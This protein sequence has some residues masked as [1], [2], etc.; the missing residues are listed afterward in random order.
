MMEW[1][2]VEKS[3]PRKPEVMIMADLLK[4]TPDHAFGVCIRFWMWCDSHLVDGVAPRITPKMLDKVLEQRGFSQAMAEVGWVTFEDDLLTVINFDKHM[5]KCAKV[6]AEDGLRQKEHREAKKK[7][8]RNCH[9][10]SV[11]NPLPEEEKR[12][13]EDKN[14]KTPPNPPPGVAPTE[15][16]PTAPTPEPIQERDADPEPESAPLGLIP[17]GGDLVPEGELAHAWTALRAGAGW[18]VPAGE[19]YGELLAFFREKIRIGKDPHRIREAI[20][21]PDRDR[22]EKLWQ[23]S[24][25]ELEE[26]ARHAAQ[27]RITAVED[28]MQA[29]LEDPIQKRSLEIAFHGWK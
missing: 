7:V 22:T 8:S 18:R 28:A 10:K 27:N 15:P 4:V 26:P 23:F 20:E 25:R 5:S 14:T 29:M 12:R 3:T 1:I 11:T 9:E 6:R 17:A 16:E 13:E 24:R 19:T 2:K 21:N